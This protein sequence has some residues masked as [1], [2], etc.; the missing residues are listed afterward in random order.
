M[1]AADFFQVAEGGTPTEA[2]TNG[3]ESAA[4][5]YG[6]AGYTGTLAEKFDVVWV[7]TSRLITRDEAEELFDHLNERSWNYGGEPTPL[8]S[9]VINTPEELEKIYDNFEDKWASAIGVEIV[10]TRADGKRQFA[11]MGWA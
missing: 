2:F 5:D 7:K 10:S 11:F 9:W 8:P 6:H 1:G 4:Y 3:V